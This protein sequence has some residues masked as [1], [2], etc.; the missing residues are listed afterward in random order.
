[1]SSLLRLLP[2]TVN[3]PLTPSSLVFGSV[4]LVPF[5]DVPEEAAKNYT[6]DSLS[7][8]R[9]IAFRAV[10]SAVSHGITEFDTAPLYGKG[11]SEDRLGAALNAL[12]PDVRTT[13]YTKTGRLIRDSTSLL[14]CEPGFETNPNSTSLLDRIAVSDMSATGARLS[15]KESLERLSLPKV[16]GL[17]IHDPNDI[18][19]STEP[20]YDEVAA[21]V[22]PGGMCDGLREMRD[23]G[24]IESVGLGMNCNNVDHQGVPDEVIRLIRSSKPGTFDHAMLAGGWNL[25]CQTGA[26]CLLECQENNMEVHVAGVYASG[27]LVGGTTYA[28]REA[29]VEMKK[30]VIEWSSLA[31]KYNVSLPAVAMAFASLPQCVSRVVVGMATE[32]QVEM[33]IATMQESNSV[34]REIWRE[35]MEKGLLDLSVCSFIDEEKAEEDAALH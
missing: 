17:R 14:P 11:G 33:N 23:E 30:R 13:V 2:R 4:W 35:A 34:P 18:V 12:P 28:Y 7:K 5:L 6:P 15:H 21:C 31:D 8:S 9:E 22:E 19:A 24:L 10:S 26:S 16:K 32:A 25:L 20:T 27:L 29:P 1:M 3:N